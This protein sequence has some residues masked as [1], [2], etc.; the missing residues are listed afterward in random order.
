VQSC[1]P[2]LR[3]SC[4]DRVAPFARPLGWVVD[5]DLRGPDAIVAAE[6]F[7]EL[8]SPKRHGAWPYDL[9]AEWAQLHLEWLAIADIPE[10]HL[11]MLD[12]RAARQHVLPPMIER[13]ATVQ[14]YL[15]LV[16]VKLVARRTHDAVTRAALRQLT[17]DPRILE[18][19]ELLEVSL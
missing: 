11:L 3:C 10:R 7:R 12:I 18:R 15:S 13:C 4:V 17:R 2:D 8:P 5:L 14:G 9:V 19:L 16:G 1:R 6:F